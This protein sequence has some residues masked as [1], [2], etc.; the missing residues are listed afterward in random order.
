MAKKRA[1]A[2]PASSTELAEQ[3]T[4]TTAAPRDWESQREFWQTT[5]PFDP[6]RTLDSRESRYELGKALREQT[7]RESHAAWAPSA[8]RADPVATVLASNAG[9]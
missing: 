1:S 5:A 4:V 6:V 7:P 8:D 9:R 3:P 2:V